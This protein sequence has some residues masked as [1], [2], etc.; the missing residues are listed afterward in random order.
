MYEFI[1]TYK[2]QFTLS[3]DPSR[4]D[5]DA[6]AEMLQRAYWA[7]GRPRE[8]TERAFDHSLV[9]GIYEETKQVG[10]ARI[11][12]DYGVF[13]YLC[14]VFIHEDYRGHGLGKWLME[15]IMSHPDLQGLRRWA[16]ATRDAH[17]LYQQYGWNPVRNPNG[18][19]EILLPFPGEENS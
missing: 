1:E 19:M 5:R 9:F 3:T 18:W 15:T 2:D 14:D 13:A 17:G 4:L 11:V 6:I 7:I 10:F 12:T 16:L 8:N